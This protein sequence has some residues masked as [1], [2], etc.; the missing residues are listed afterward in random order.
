MTEGSEGSGLPS[1]ASDEQTRLRAEVAALRREP[2][3]RPRGT[4]RAG[5][6]R[7]GVGSR[8]SVGH[9][10]VRADHTPLAH[11]PAVQDAIVSR[12]T[13]TIF[14][15]LD[16]AAL[17]QEAVA[18]LAAQGLPTRVANG[19]DGLSRPLASGVR[20]FVAE[21]V[22][23]FV[24]SPEFVDAWVRANRQTSSGPPTS[25]PSG[26][27]YCHGTRLRS[28]TTRWSTTSV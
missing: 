16:V 26:A 22:R 21:R 13:D 9:G 23:R 28:Y 7:G 20:S 11:D 5:L 10:S 15:R 27:P 4:G 24:R 3:D 17:T 19:L 25:M 6:D 1:A 14:T 18:A 8:P 2:P 12:V